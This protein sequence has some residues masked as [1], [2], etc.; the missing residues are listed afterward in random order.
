MTTMPDPM[1][2]TRTGPRFLPTE[3]RRAHA[4]AL[5]ALCIAGACHYLAGVLMV[6]LGIDA[7]WGMYLVAGTFF[8]LLGL[9]LWR[10]VNV[11]Y[12]ELTPAGLVTRQFRVE[13]IEWH[14][15]TGLQPERRGR[16]WRV[17]VHRR[18]GRSLVLIAPLTRA[19]RPD[20]RFGAELEA[21]HAW[22]R[23]AAGP[24][25]TGPGMSRSWP[26]AG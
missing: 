22:W 18:T 4:V 25:V 15:I 24:G 1:Q 23:A 11:G 10:M 7:L 12:T 14:A 21:M 16:Y 3:A 20:R 9:W 26:P 2:P 8:I 19:S 13:T 5:V 17:R 6:V